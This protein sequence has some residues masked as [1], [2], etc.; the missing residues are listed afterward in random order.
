M[1]IG[2]VGY[3]YVGKAY[4]KVFPDAIIYDEPLKIGKREEINKCDM[5][6]IS[7]PTDPMPDGSLDMFIVESVV[8]W[9]KSPL[10]LIK[11]ALM[12]GTVDLLV[13][14][15]GKKIAVSIE[16]VGM[17]K[18]YVPPNY[19]DPTDPT[20]HQMI[21]IGGEEETATKC[22]ELLWEKMSP[23][24]RIYLNTALEVEIGKLV[25]NTYPALKVTF[26]NCLYNLAKKS[27]ANWIRLHQG[28]TADPRVDGMHLRTTSNKRGWKSHCWDKDIPA[29]K[30][31]AK[32]VGAE[33]MYELIE[34]IIELNK[35][36]CD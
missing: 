4:H 29:L 35:K 1:K 11:S 19:P 12:P 3:G 22:A 9:V 17:G 8:N 20:K 36:H 16:Y 10:I 18:Y 34:K 13:K 23:T 6:I 14:K 31:Y 32:D 30:K 15:T 2:I 24:V 28:W 21:V 33:D 7:V 27:G 5:A 26:I 25:E